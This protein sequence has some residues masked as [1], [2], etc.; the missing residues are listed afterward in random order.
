MGSVFFNGVKIMESDDFHEVVPKKKKSNKYEDRPYFE[1]ELIEC[2]KKNNRVL[3][4]N[5]DKIKFPFYCTF[6]TRGVFTRAIETRIGEVHRGIAYY[7]LFDVT[8]QT[9]DRTL[10]QNADYLDELIKKYNINIVK[11]KLLLFKK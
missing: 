9:K 1:T 7:S 6:E 10:V 11:G 3:N 2:K 5:L 8:E 4:E